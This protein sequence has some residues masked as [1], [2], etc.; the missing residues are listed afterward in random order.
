MD[1][2]VV[3]LFLELFYINFVCIRMFSFIFITEK[4]V[5]LRN[6]TNSLNVKQIAVKESCGTELSK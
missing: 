6:E 5:G 4:F 2:Q 3:L 1:L